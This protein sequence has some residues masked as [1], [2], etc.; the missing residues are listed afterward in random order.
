[1]PSKE[2]YHLWLYHYYGYAHDCYRLM[3]LLLMSALMI[4]FPLH[5]LEMVMLLLMMMVEVVAMM[6]D[7][8]D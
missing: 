3:L 7:R 8:N 6:M 5:Y 1:M 2:R 4:H